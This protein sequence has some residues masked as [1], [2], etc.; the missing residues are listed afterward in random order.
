MTPHPAPATS[1]VHHAAVVTDSLTSHHGEAGV[2]CCVV[3][4]VNCYQYSNHLLL[5]LELL[6]DSDDDLDDFLYPDSDCA[7]GHRRCHHDDNPKKCHKETL[8]QTR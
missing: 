4:V 2:V 3:N 8:P 7:H 6:H 5:L 1:L